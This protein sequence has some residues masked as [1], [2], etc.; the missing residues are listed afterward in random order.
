MRRCCHG[1]PKAG[2]EAIID[3]LQQTHRFNLYQGNEAG[4]IQERDT[5]RKR[6]GQ[7]EILRVPEIFV[8]SP[9]P[10]ALP[11]PP[12]PPPT[13]SQLFGQEASYGARDLTP[14]PSPPIGLQPFG[15]GAP[16]NYSF[17][18]S[19]NAGRR[20]ALLVRSNYFG[21]RGQLRS[22]ISAVKNMS[23]LLNEDFGYAPGHMI[24]LTDDQTPFLQPTK[25]NILCAMH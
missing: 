18:D 13:V 15:H 5:A 16:K 3:L 9:P 10:L 25:A 6:V 7:E 22:C 14:S 8:S 1:L 21:Q 20:K 19:S 12:P 4:W 24:I 17:R 2:N 23:T 11:P